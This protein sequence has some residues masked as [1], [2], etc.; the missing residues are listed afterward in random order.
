[1]PTIFYNDK[2][3]QMKL[4]NIFGILGLIVIVSC[5]SETKKNTVDNSIKQ[6]DKRKRQVAS[7]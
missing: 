3:R 6:E 4:K 1:M 2:S 7:I 5:S